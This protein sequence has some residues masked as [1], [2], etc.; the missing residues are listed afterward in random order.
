MDWKFVLVLFA[1]NMVSLGFSLY[2]SISYHEEN[3]YVDYSLDAITYSEKNVT[4][5][6]FSTIEYCTYFRKEYF[7]V[8][9]AETVLAAVNTMLYFVL[10]G[11]ILLILNEVQEITQDT[12]ISGTRIKVYALLKILIL[13]ITSVEIAATALTV[14]L[15]AVTT[16]NCNRIDFPTQLENASTYIVLLFLES[17]YIV[18]DFINN[19][20]DAENVGGIAEEVEEDVPFAQPNVNYVVM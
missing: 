16:K 12:M 10:L 5:T 19:K 13:I 1:I 20:E 2:H 18:L 9:I 17:S 11:D 8:V 6:C 3:I 15:A 14:Y 4:Y 7:P